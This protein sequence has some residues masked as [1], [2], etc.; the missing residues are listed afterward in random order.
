MLFTENIFLVID[1]I[2][3]MILELSTKLQNIYSIA[4]QFVS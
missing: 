4:I 2:K 1:K 3:Q